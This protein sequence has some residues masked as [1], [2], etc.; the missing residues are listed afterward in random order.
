[1]RAIDTEPRPQEAVTDPTL[2]V[3]CENVLE[4]R[5]RLTV[6]RFLRSRLGIGAGY[7]L[8]LPMQ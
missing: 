8:R 7:L 4:S 1:M 3:K 5:F 2:Y 6:D